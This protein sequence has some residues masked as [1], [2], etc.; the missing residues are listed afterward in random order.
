MLQ[1]A[2]LPLGSTTL[3]A[4]MLVQVTAFP[5]LTLS[6]VSAQESAGYS[7]GAWASATHREPCVEFLP[8]GYSLN[9]SQQLGI[10]EA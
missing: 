8:P 5:L 6:P 3:H 1:R 10:I 9:Q 4:G 7:T 2:N